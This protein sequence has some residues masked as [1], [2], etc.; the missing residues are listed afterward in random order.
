MY[1]Q[2][3]P[4][5]QFFPVETFEIDEEGIQ[6]KSRTMTGSDFG[7]C[8]AAIIGYPNLL[9]FG[10]YRSGMPESYRPCVFAETISGDRESEFYCSSESNTYESYASFQQ[11]EGELAIQ[12]SLPNTGNRMTNAVIFDCTGR[13]VASGSY[14]FGE[15]IALPVPGLYFVMTRNI[16]GTNDVIRLTI[17][18]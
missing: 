14:S 9:I 13:T 8:D 16:D 15:K 11:I 2:S 18:K 12:L 17:V 6:D 1:W 10:T 3:A 7:A 4:F 5:N